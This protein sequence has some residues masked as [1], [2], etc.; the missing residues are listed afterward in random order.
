MI[1][2]TLGLT[3]NKSLYILT[4]ECHAK[5]GFKISESGSISGVFHVPLLD[6]ARSLG[7]E[8]QVEKDLNNESIKEALAQHRFVLLSIDL[9]KTTK[10]HTGGHLILVHTYDK[11]S[12][13]FIVHD[14]AHT[15]ASNGKNAVLPSR[16]LE[17]YSNKKG[18]TLFP[19]AC[20]K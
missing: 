13:T 6:Y 12:D 5:G 3:T 19:P 15:V 2:D 11:A 17:N 20:G 14:C 4:K 1:G 8:G 10:N 7:L 16:T 9:A 18:L